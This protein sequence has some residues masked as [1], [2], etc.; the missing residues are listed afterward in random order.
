MD[1]PGITN[2]LEE[3]K[4]PMPF[5]RRARVTN[6]RQASSELLMPET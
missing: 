1:P 4:N 6:S 2:Y 3:L 5:T